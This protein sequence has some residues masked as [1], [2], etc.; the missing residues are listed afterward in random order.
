MVFLFHFGFSFCYRGLCLPSNYSKVDLPIQNETNE[1]KI[2]FL[3][4]EV[5]D[6]SDE[7]HS[8]SISSILA[9]EWYDSRLSFNGTDQYL[10]FPKDVSDM[11]W[12][13]DIYFWNAKTF[14]TNQFVDGRPIS[15]FGY[16]QNVNPNV[17]YGLFFQAEIKC[18]MRFDKY[19]FDHHICYLELSSYRYLFEQLFLNVT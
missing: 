8:F 11:F 14:E 18:K 7:R 12:K 5:T 6:I 2:K 17:G 16:Q 15:E 19:P 3:F 9:V 4:V 1:V 13:P 10:L